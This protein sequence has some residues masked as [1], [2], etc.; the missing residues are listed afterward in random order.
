LHNHLQ[1]KMGIDDETTVPPDV[2]MGPPSGGEQ[3]AFTRQASSHFWAKTN[4]S[5]P[6]DARGEFIAKVYS[7]LCGQLLITVGICALCMYNDGVRNYM[8]DNPLLNE[9]GFGIS[10]LVVMFVL[11][12]VPRLKTTPPLNFLVLAIFT[13]LESFFIGVLCAVYY[14][15]GQGEQIISAFIITIGIFIGLTIFAMQ[16]KIDWS[17]LGGVLLAALLALIWWGVVIAIF[18]WRDG[19]FWYSLLGAFIFCLFILYDTNQICT[20]LGY[21]Q[22]IAA[23]LDLYLDILNLFLYILSLLGKK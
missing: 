14:E 11:L 18:G 23:A 16:S 22:Y 21:D 8:I 5:G 9:L 2:E 13:A 7:I 15:I 19:V 3:P 12:L 17:W 1:G 6:H 10:A 4:Y 20:K